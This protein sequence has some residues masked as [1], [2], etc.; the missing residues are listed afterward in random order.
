[1]L[2]SLSATQAE[3]TKMIRT[4]EKSQSEIAELFKV[5][6]ST[7]SRMITEVREKELLKA[8]R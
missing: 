7:I 6:R 8:A 4:G 1:V 2:P 3:A 5:D